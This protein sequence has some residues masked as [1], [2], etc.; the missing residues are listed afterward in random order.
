MST[1]LDRWDRRYTDRVRLLVEIL[2]VLAQEPRF[3]LKGRLSPQLCR[4][5]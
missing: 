5:G 4:R 3:A 1:W 2:P